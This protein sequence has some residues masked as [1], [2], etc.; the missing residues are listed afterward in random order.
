MFYLYFISRLTCLI[1]ILFLAGCAT[2]ITDKSRVNTSPTVVSAD[3]S[4]QSVSQGDASF[5]SDEEFEYADIDNQ[6]YDPLEGW[7]RV[8]FAFNDLTYFFIARPISKGYDFIVP[9]PVRTGIK[10]FFH[11]L[12]FPVRFFGNLLQGK[13]T[14]A[15][16]EFA[17][18]MVNSTFG[19]GGLIDFYQ[20]VEP[21]NPLKDDEDMGQVLASMGVGDGFYIVWP[22]IGPS[23]AR[24]TLGLIGD[25][26]LTP[27]TYIRH[28]ESR[29][30]I[31]GGFQ[32]N[33]LSDY[34]YAYDNM[35][36]NALEPYSAVRD[37]YIQ[38]RKGKL[39]R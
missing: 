3:S 9:S 13:C 14:K 21:N 18:F 29:L 31:N 12:T 15:G 25:I 16:F 32:L 34:L 37:A 6:V 20:R 27:T 33:S 4:V 39:E 7:N 28:W 24:D 19:V 26:L 36:Q 10:N 23:T 30:A 17:Q 22:L 2:H 5:D 11:N 1:L 35:R 8:M 38:F